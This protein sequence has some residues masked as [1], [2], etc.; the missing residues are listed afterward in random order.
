MR[1]YSGTGPGM[2]LR[3][4]RATDTWR[5]HF[6]ST[7]VI[8]E[9]YRFVNSAR[10]NKQQIKIRLIDGMIVKMYCWLRLGN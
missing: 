5:H 4:D 2:G 1:P 6:R 10:E 9:L 3:S 8:A 7:V